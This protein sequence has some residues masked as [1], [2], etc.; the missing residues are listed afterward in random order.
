MHTIGLSKMKLLHHQW[1]KSIIRFS[2]ISKLESSGA[3]REQRPF[4]IAPT[5]QVRL[6]RSFNLYTYRPLASPNAIAQN[7]AQ[8][9]QTRR[10]AA[11]SV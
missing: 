11:I 9:L 10:A 1:A 8:N 4:A 3:K 5:R 6:K 7:V 2:C